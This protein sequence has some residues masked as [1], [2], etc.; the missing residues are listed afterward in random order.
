MTADKRIFSLFILSALLIMAN[1]SSGVSTELPEE[2]MILGKEEP[3][4]FNID[5]VP[6][7]FD[8]DTDPEE[9]D[10]ATKKAGER[11][12]T[13]DV[14]D[15]TAQIKSVLKTGN[16]KDDFTIDI[17]SITDLMVKALYKSHTE[18]TNINLEFQLTFDSIVEYF[19]N[20]SD[21]V[22]NSDEDTVIQELILDSFQPFEYDNG[23]AHIIVIN[24]TDGVFLVRIFAVEGYTD[25]N[26]TIVSPAEIKIDFEFHNFPFQEDTSR[27]A[28]AIRFQTNAAYKWR[29]T[30]KG[31][32]EE[33]AE[34]ETAVELEGKDSSGYFAWSNY[35]EADGEMVEVLGS[36]LKTQGNEKNMFLN[37]PH[38]IDI[39][40]DPKIGVEDTSSFIAGFPLIVIHSLL[41]VAGLYM[42]I[43]KGRK[44]RKDSG[45][46]YFKN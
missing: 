35:A 8:I 19:D 32:E 16:V 41:G 27:L 13:I 6:N 10:N 45:F 42:G 44:H 28:L 38:A 1:I 4:V 23:T 43:R 9:V 24:S 36:P 18:S 25:I 40:H 33:L 39:V 2:G 3:G 26:N 14:D 37:Y 12:V 30:T 29:N 20:N 7:E 22:Y 46:T 15:N 21:G 17:T 5:T 11:V 31:E 34:E